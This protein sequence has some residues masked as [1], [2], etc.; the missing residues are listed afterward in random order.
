[1]IDGVD[2]RRSRVMDAVEA[3]NRRRKPGTDWTDWLT[4]IASVCSKRS[5]CVRWW[6]DQ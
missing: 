3:N 1:M 4:A 5:A 6:T 2:I